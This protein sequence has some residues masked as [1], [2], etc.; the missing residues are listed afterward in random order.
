VVFDTQAS[1]CGMRAAGRRNAAAAELAEGKDILSG[2][3]RARPD[4]KSTSHTLQI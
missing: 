1:R 4:G 2:D 3:S